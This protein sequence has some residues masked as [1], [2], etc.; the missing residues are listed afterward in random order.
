MR[1]YRTNCAL[2]SNDGLCVEMMV[3]D[4]GRVAVAVGSDVAEALDDLQREWWRIERRE[5]RHALSLDAGR[6]RAG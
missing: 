2:S 3:S 6:G 1:L 4:G 5:A